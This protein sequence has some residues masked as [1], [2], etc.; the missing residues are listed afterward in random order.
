MIQIDNSNESMP[1]E[2][3]HLTYS[4]F[5]LFY[6]QTQN[7]SISKTAIPEPQTIIETINNPVGISN[8]LNKS[9][10]E[11]KLD[12]AQPQIAT[13]SSASTG[14]IHI[15]DTADQKNGCVIM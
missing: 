4:L 8:N 15:I 2:P 6:F 7:L 5:L 12:S 3:F 11:P 10:S 13:V 14:N 1:H 9:V